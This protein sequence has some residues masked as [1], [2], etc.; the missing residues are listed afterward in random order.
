MAKCSFFKKITGKENECVYGLAT[1]LGTDLKPSQFDAYLGYEK[2]DFDVYL[3]HSTDKS[4]NS[5]A[6]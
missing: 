2:S 5:F 1:T 4:T 3:K 6:P